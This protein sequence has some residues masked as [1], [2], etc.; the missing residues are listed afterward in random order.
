METVMNSDM[1]FV[2]FGRDKFELNKFEKV[3]NNRSY[4]YKPV[5]GGFWA[6]PENSKHNWEN[7]FDLDDI[8]KKSISRFKLKDNAKIL[9]IFEESDLK[10]LP[11]LSNKNK[12]EKAFDYEKLSEIYDVIY[13]NPLDKDT[14]SQL[15]PC[16]DCEC[17]YVMNPSVIVKING[18]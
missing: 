13:Y 5:I 7:I 10:D 2:H 3:K 6:S 12:A 1:I 4:P 15:L 16:W 9:K 11:V 8:Q 17:I 18:E 14:M